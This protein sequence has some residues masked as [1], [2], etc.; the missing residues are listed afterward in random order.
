[1]VEQKMSLLSS[2]LSRSYDALADIWSDGRGWIFL[3]I[4][5]GWFLSIGIRL[6]FPVLIPFIR[7]DLNIS[8]SIAGTILSLLW[9]AYAF[10]QFP[11]GILG[12][13]IGERNILTLSTLLAGLGV[14]I[15]LVSFNIWMFIL[16]TVIF[17]FGTAF[18][19][20]TRI[21]ILTDLY[22][23]RSGTAIG[24]M[25]ASGDLGNVTLPFLA[26]VIATAL[27]WQFGFGFTIPIFIVAALT[28]WYTVPQN[29]SKSSDDVGAQP[30][31]FGKAL[32]GAVRHHGVVLG[33][34]IQTLN[35]FVWQGFTGFYPTYLIDAKGFAPTTASLVF[36]MFFAL[37]MLIRIIAGTLG[38]RF[39]T[40]LP[41]IVLLPIIAASIISFPFVNSF[42]FIILL[43]IP[44]STLLGVGPIIFPYLVNSFPDELQG[45]GFGL[46]RTFYMFIGALGPIFVGVLADIELFDEAFFIL[47]SLL[48][49][50]WLLTFTIRTE[51]RE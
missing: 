8:L 7:T 44:L 45:S 17:G 35:M 36:A 22:P 18:Y 19:G 29:T 42:W 26:G 13:K 46:V 24:L 1:M 20:T 37:G 32:L 21:T 15:I 39:G 33:T 27:A 3:A 6:I 51:H 40:Q 2:A 49:V 12:D 47:G 41:L 25:L 14:V 16:G 38:D 48:L 23:N 5:L 50:A 10:G 43:T 11:G 30:L 31:N 28:I 9:V 34:S 4:S